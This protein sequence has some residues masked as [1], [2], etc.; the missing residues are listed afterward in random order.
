M[1]WCEICRKMMKFFLLPFS[2][3]TRF[4]PSLILKTHFPAFGVFFGSFR[5]FWW[6]TMFA[7]AQL[8]CSLKGFWMN[9]K[10]LLIFWM[11]YKVSFKYGFF[12]GKLAATQILWIS[13][14]NY[15]YMQKGVIY[16]FPR[17]PY[18]LSIFLEFPGCYG[19]RVY[20]N[21]NEI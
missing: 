13:I 9:G 17:F 12:G 16:H 7:L 3:F 15:V 19:L 20:F 4:F 6:F 8:T 11:D 18:F 5:V 1:V 10:K 14:W 2:V 21:I